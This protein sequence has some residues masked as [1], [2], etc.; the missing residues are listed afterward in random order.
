MLSRTRKLEQAQLA[1]LHPGI[2]LDRQRRHV[3]KLQ[4]HVTRKPRIDE[5]CGGVG[6][7]AEAA[8]RGLA[9]KPAG[10]VVGQGDYLVGGTEHKLTGMQDEWLITLGLDQAGEVGLLDARVDVGVSVVLK[11]AEPAVKA[12]VDARRLDHR[13][14]E[15]LDG[16]ASGVH[17]GKEVAV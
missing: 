13:L 10:D 11:D 9:L 15:G 16:Y 5:P 6:E 1:D 12:D 7:Q 4:R 8:E 17:F 2:Q 14:V 3:R